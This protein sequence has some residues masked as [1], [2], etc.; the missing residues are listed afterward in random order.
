MSRSLSTQSS[1]WV[2]GL[3]IFAGFVMIT[4]GVFH[5]L[6]GIAAVIQGDFFVVTRDYAYKL[7][8]SVWG[9][10]HLAG[11]IILVLAGVYVF[12]GTLWA[13]IVG[14]VLAASSAIANFFFA[15]YYPVWAILIIALDVVVIW[16]LATYR[17]APQGV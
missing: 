8:V 6:E 3:V 16:A 12:S 11:G 15:P 13:R 14:M 9:W 10:I 17:P 7:D 1:G 4:I 5:I 2:P